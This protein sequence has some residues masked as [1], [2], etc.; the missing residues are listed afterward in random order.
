MNAMITSAKILGAST[1][2][3]VVQGWRVGR[4]AL[5]RPIVSGLLV[6]GMVLYVVMR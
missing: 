1:C 6:F 2:V 5:R 3:A 4:A